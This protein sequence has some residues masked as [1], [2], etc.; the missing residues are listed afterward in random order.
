MNSVSDG[1]K[2]IGGVR[3]VVGGFYYF[4]MVENSKDIC[5]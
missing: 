2:L 3:R 1:D 4:V 5:R